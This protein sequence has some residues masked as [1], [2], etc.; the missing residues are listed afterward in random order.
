MALTL[1]KKTGD[2]FTADEFNQVVAEINKKTNAVAG[3]GFSENDY[4]NAEKKKLA[5]TAQLIEDL[6]DTGGTYNIVSSQEREVGKLRWGGKEYMIYEQTAELSGLP[7]TAGESINIVLSDQPCGND[8]YLKTDCL[9]VATTSGFATS[10]YEVKKIFVDSSFNTVATILCK[11]AVVNLTK[12]LLTIRYVKG[13]LSFSTMNIRVPL[14]A[15]A[16]GVDGVSISIPPCK[17]GKSFALSFVGDDSLMGI[18][19]R[20]FNYVFGRWVDDKDIF[21]DGETPTTGLTPSR[22][23]LFTDGCGNDIPFRLG[24]NWMDGKEGQNI[25]ANGNKVLPYMWWKEG[26]RFFDYYNA[27]LNHGGGDQTKPLES[28]VN[29]HNTIVAN[30]N[31]VPCVLGVPGGTTGY[32][33]A[34]EGLEYIYMLESSSFDKYPQL[35]TISGNI[36]KHRF[37]R[38]CIDTYNLDQIKAVL[39]QYGKDYHWVN[40]FCHNIQN[41]TTTVNGQL[42]ANVCFA[43]LD[44][45]YTIYGKGGNDSVWFASDSEIFEYLFTRLNSI[46]TKKVDGNDLLITIKAAKLPNFCYDELSLSIQGVNS[47]SGISYSDNIT[48]AS[49]KTNLINLIY[50]TRTAELA[51][52]YVSAFEVNNTDE[53]KREAYF[54]VNRLKEN[55]KASFVARLSTGEVAPILNSIAINGGAATTYNRTVEIAL[56]VTGSISHYKVAENSNLSEADWIAGT[57][58]NISYDISSGYTTKKVY[59]HVKNQYGESETKNASITL[60][61]QP[62]V[63]FTVTGKSNNASWGSVIPAS[64]QVG[65]GDSV[66]LTATAQPNYVI[67]SWTEADSF[68]GIGTDSGTAT[69]TNVQTD[70]IITCKFK[71]AST[72]PNVK[73]AIIFPAK[74][75]SESGL[76]TLPSGE[77]ATKIFGLNSTIT[78]SFPIYD[79][80]GQKIG[81]RISLTSLL[82]SDAITFTTSDSSDPILTGNTGVYPDEYLSL[83]LGAYVKETWPLGRGLIRIVNI[84]S[85]IYNIKILV[86]TQKALT[87]TQVSGITYDANGIISNPPSGFNATN[88]NSQFVTIENVVVSPDRILDIY[89]GN[90]QAWVRASWNAIE[91]EKIS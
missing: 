2:Q 4:T 18:Y 60:K 32:P 48:F 28:I 27:I 22:Q 78:E 89:M 3:K 41:A 36:L 1:H 71:L 15:L 72:T 44:Y 26:I 7:T 40:L 49:A 62:S 90:T 84:E 57:S 47:V 88:N 82:P 75:G 83:L 69:A 6:I 21:H 76:I 51:E 65:Q 56:N 66:S 85:G 63:V 5:D 30:M 39:T 34:S 29:N 61:E 77:K 81:D 11:E 73:K 13:M 67:E 17:Y 86:S 10:A 33:E 8:L 46:I 12:T 68:T 16:G 42:N 50:S 79:T 19:Q 54:F 45:V 38:L 9:S 91:I 31:V 52:K 59:V 87:E 64:Q 53:N 20:A 24:V 58:K 55:L 14:T 25:H 74:I 43:F 80:T 23:L 35:S 37:G 70:K